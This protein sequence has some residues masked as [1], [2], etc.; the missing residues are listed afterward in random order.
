MTYLMFI[1]TELLGGVFLYFAYVG[2]FDMATSFAIVILMLA[3]SF[4]VMVRKPDATG[5][6][7]ACFTTV[8]WMSSV[9]SGRLAFEFR[10]WAITLGAFLVFIIT[11]S[12]AA[13]ATYAIILRPSSL[14]LGEN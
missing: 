8:L 14:D 7:L 9:I 6:R 11:I 4:H 3:L 2:I 5:I 1:M 12:A 10:G 13:L